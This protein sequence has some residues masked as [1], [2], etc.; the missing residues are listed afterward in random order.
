MRRLFIFCTFLLIGLSVSAQS[1]Q[2]QVASG[3]IQGKRPETISDNA[4]RKTDSVTGITNQSIRKKL[5]SSKD[6]LTLSDYMM[7][8]DRVNDNLN[9][10]M[11]SSHLG[12]EAVRMGRRIDEISN[13]IVTIRKNMRGRSSAFNLKNLYLYQS[14]ASELDDQNDRIQAHVAKLYHRI[15][16]TK[17]SLKT[18]L[19][20]SVFR[21]IYADNSLR[22]SF[23]KKLIRLER[24]YDRSD[25][26]AK[27]NIDT[28]NALKVKIADN[29]VNLANMLNMMDVRL[30]RADRQLFRP[31]VSFLWQNQNK[32]VAANSSSKAVIS[33][34]DSERNA[35]SF[36]F[37]RTSG[38]RTFIVFLGILL[39]IWLFSKRK[40]IKKLRGKDDQLSFLHIQY[41]NS[42]PFLSLLVLLI[43]LMPFFDA[44]APTSYIAIE[45]TLLL[46][47]SSAIFLER[48]LLT[49]GVTG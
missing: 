1:K 11:D 29:S 31:E 39:L 32:V 35:V 5:I 24:K 10:V 15:Y 8:I 17:L 12:F 16:S 2:M 13:D 7:S 19:Y 20:D 30:D 18:V 14:F 38:K 41:L 42:Y 37:N 27:A 49:P 9:S 4:K 21:A 48:K 44:Y 47:A 6:T 45:Y 43:C 23:D 3:V 36:Y 33:K 46:L 26:T 22:K 40:L 34:L 25:S 28:L